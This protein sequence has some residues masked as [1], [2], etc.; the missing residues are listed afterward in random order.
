M[1]QVR[2]LHMDFAGFLGPFLGPIDLRDKDKN[3]A[4]CIKVTD[5]TVVGTFVHND[6]HS[7]IIEMVTILSLFCKKYA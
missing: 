4:V 1:R 3:K 7:M 6:L 2:I 5:V